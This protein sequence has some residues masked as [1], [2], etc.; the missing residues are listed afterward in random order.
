VSSR[1]HSCDTTP[2]D[3]SSSTAQ[4]ETPSRGLRRC[5]TCRATFAR[6]A[7]PLALVCQ[8]LVAVGVDVPLI[9]FLPNL[10]FELG[11]GLWLL[12]RG[13]PRST[14]AVRAD[15]Q[16]VDGQHRIADGGVT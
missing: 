5:W 8:A 3:V 2:S 14:Q 7:A 12:L 4:L 11:A 16:H 9:L 1:S 13:R 10:P 6:V 15:V